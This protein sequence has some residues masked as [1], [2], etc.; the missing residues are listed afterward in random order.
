MLALNTI[1]LIQ[2]N[3]KDVLKLVGILGH[4][5]MSVTIIKISHLMDVITIVN[6]CKISIVKLILM[7]KQNAHILEI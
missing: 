4:K 5:I 6:K 7:D 2:M 3:L 1:K